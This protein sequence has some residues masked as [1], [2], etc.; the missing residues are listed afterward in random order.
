M[1]L[2]LQLL[3]LLNLGSDII[4]DYFNIHIHIHTDAHKHVCLCMHASVQQYL[5]MG[6]HD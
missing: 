5:C 3:D 1:C 4:V 2:L 6:S